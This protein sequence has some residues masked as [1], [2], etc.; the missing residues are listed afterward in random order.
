LTL[1][2]LQDTNRCMEAEPL[3]R[4][5]LAI[6][7]QCFG[8]D[9]PSV[10]FSLNNIAGLLRRTGKAIE[11]EPFYKKAIEIFLR[12]SKANNSNHPF[13]QNAIDNFTDLLAD[14]GLEPK[15][16]EL[17]LNMITL[18]LGAYIRFKPYK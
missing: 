17:H 2:L 13:L 16:I 14:M 18:P 1:T 5:A 12:F 15:E 6:Q 7:L 3:M 9:H 10:G 4:R 11:A 8:D